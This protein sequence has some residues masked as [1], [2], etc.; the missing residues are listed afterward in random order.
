TAAGA[1]PSDVSVFL[2][3]FGGMGPNGRFGSFKNTTGYTFTGVPA[4]GV[5]LVVFDNVTG[6]IAIADGVVTTGGVLTL[7]AQLGN[8]Q[9]LGVNLDGADGFRYDAT[10]NG[11]LGSG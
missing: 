3:G 8:G 10:A 9:T 6:A 4:G 5:Q 7:N 11:A 2:E 1:A